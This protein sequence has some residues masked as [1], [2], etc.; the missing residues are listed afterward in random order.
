MAKY[1]QV[2]ED[3]A[4]LDKVYVKPAH[5][6]QYSL[7]VAAEVPPGMKRI[8]IWARIRGGSLQLKTDRDGKN[9]ELKWAYHVPEE[10]TWVNFGTYDRTELGPN[11]RIVSAPGSESGIDALLFDP[12]GKADPRDG[13]QDHG[14]KEH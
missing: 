14:T 9:E 5:A 3:S 4:A 2:G 13:S 11:I 6:E 8:A 7:L 12:T 1:A 10:W